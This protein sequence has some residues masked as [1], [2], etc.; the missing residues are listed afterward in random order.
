MVVRATPGCSAVVVRVSGKPAGPNGSDAAA[1]VTV[2]VV[3]VG[4]AA[5]AVTMDGVAT[6]AS[7]AIELAKRRLI[8]EVTTANV[9]LGVTSGK[10]STTLT[11][12]A[13]ETLSVPH[14]GLPAKR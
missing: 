11:K 2:G 13:R 12:T 1:A 4:E 3:A 14:L 5:C 8:G 9:V 6:M 7:K 10:P